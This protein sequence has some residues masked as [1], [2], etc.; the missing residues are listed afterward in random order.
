LLDWRKQ[1]KNR[2]IK[3][4][5]LFSLPPPLAHQFPPLTEEISCLFASYNFSDLTSGLGAKGQNISSIRPILP[6]TVK[7]S[8]RSGGA[9]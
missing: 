7:S 4:T 9:L 5:K 1:D 8:Y 3:N 6:G 2:K